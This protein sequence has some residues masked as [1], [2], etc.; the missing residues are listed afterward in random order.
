MKKLELPYMPF[1]VGD[2]LT[3]TRHLTIE[4]HGAYFLLILEYWTKGELPNDDEQLARILGI[5]LGKW[6]KMRPTIQAFFHDGWRHE[7]LDEQLAKSAELKQQAVERARKG[8]QALREKRLQSGKVVPFKVPS[9][10][11]LISA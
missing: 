1:F 2:Y 10:D 6:I 7:L 3:G 8:G 5:S 9:K 4:Q 11:D